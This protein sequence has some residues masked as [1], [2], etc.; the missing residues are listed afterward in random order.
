MKKIVFAIIVVSTASASASLV[1]SDSTTNFRYE[2]YQQEGGACC[3]RSSEIVTYKGKVIKKVEIINPFMDGGG[4]HSDSNPRV[5]I[6]SDQPISLG[7]AHQDDGYGYS[8][9]AMNITLEN[10]DSKPV[11]PD[12]KS[13]SVVTSVVCTESHSLVPRP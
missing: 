1:C 11:L 9:I 4:S 12:Q 8:E 3:G 10:L 5:K 13:S 2:H 6:T 7:N